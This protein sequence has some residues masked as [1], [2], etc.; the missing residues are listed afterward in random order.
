MAY[1]YE[2]NPITK[3]E[4]IVIDGW[5]N[6]VGLSP[7]KGLGNIQ[8]ANI[9]TEE[10]EVMCSFNRVQQSQ[11]PTTITFF[12]GTHSTNVSNN[13]NWVF[14]A[15]SIVTGTLTQVNTNTVSISGVT[16]L[17][18]TWITISN[19]GTTGLSGDY[20]Y[21]GSGKLSATFS[22]SASTIVT[23]ITSGSATFNVQGMGSPVMST[24]EFYV[25]SSGTKQY[26]Y[27]I[28]DNLGQVWVH[29]TVT[30]T[31]VDTPLWFLP[32]KKP[33]L[34]GQI[35]SGLA[36]L[37]GWLSIAVGNIFYWKPTVSL[38]TAF[39]SI[40]NFPPTGNM[41]PLMTNKFHATL[42]GHQGKMYYTDGN[43]IGSIFPNTSILTGTT[44]IQSYSSY[45]AIN[46]AGTI[47][48]VLSGS[49]PSDLISTTRI[50][51][52]FFTDSSGTQ[53]SN[54][55]VNTV[56]YIK[57]LGSNGFEV[58]AA[59]TGGSAINIQTG[60]A[61][62]QYFNTFNPL[63]V[64][65]TP[66]YTFTPQRL[67]LPIF[68]TAQCLAEVGNIVLIGGITNAIYPW[69]QVS[70]LP[71][72]IIPLP[73]SNVV[74]MITVNN[75]A[76]IFAGSKADIYVTNGSSVSRVLTV[77]DYCAGIAG[78]P[79]TYIE[80]YFVWGGAMYVRG[81]VWFSVLDQTST[82]TGNC[83][84]I[85]SFVPSQNYS[86]NQDTGL[87]LRLENR[88]SYGTYNGVCTVLL[89]SQNQNGISA[90]YWSGWYSNITNPLYGID[91]TDTI[92]TPPA[93]IQTELIP[94]GTAL[95]KKTFRQVEYK[96]ASPLANGETVAIDYRQ[97]GT[98]SFTSMGTAS[99]E[100]TTDI[101]GYFN[102][103]FEKG[104]WIQ[105]QTTLTPLASSSSSFCR[106][107]EIRIR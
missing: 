104:Q 106:L 34:N 87:S 42:V 40:S 11:S 58:Y 101:S 107:K 84:G 79:S 82:K 90:Q 9:S 7:H 103:N 80:P 67:N 45:T 70:A 56:Y 63:A 55:T 47:T 21:L 35:A 27:Y 91:F 50:P 98:D 37:N 88:S 8:A 52:Y 72:D 16:L 5:E 3:E 96:L 92:P 6:G 100:S 31:G 65:A 60:A 62:N 64:D 93:V 99:T 61:G 30:L 4:E 57:Y 86:Q 17:A 85:W 36:V 43:Y 77:P 20:Y 59:L 49:V 32:E 53:P 54:L 46:T 26:R 18:G 94:T 38:G 15:P 71:Q 73:S 66:T 48:N 76:Y 14:T 10:G 13:T 28:L 89:P 83:G 23:G 24:T 19:A 33:S 1:R 68:E 69:N 44:N 75:T 39:S 102:V 51:A 29:D 97:N 78:S 105:L 41:N 74:N 22:Q 12:A 81:R 2:K 95:Q 25:D